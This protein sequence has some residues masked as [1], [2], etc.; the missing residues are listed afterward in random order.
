MFSSLYKFEGSY[1]SEGVIFNNN[2]ITKKYKQRWKTKK[3]SRDVEM[4]FNNKKIINLKITPEEKE[5]PRI[6]YK[7]LQG[8]VDPLASFLNILANNKKSKTIDGRRVYILE[9]SYEGVFKNVLIKEYLNI[10]ADH[11]RKD[12]QFLEIYQEPGSILNI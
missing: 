8:Y 9:P 1:E 5:L 4:V 11:K 6:R 2:Y 7:D 10:W 12:L 3:K